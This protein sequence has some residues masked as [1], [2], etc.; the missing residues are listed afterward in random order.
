MEEKG[1]DLVFDRL[2][3]FNHFGNG[4]LFESR[5]FVKDIMNIVPARRKF[6]AHGKNRRMFPDLPDLLFTPVTEKMNAMRDFMIDGEDLYINTWVGR[7]SKYV[8]HRVGCVIDK[9][10]EMFNDILRAANL[11]ELSKSLL[12]YIPDPNFSYFNTKSINDF[13]VATQNKRKILMCNG[14]VGSLQA[15]NF[16]FTPMIEAVASNHKDDCFLLTT[17]TPL[18]LDNIWYT[19]DIIK[20]EDGFD[21]NEI[22]YLAKYVDII[23]G[24][25]SGPFVFAHPRDVWFD[26]TKKSLSF[27]YEAHSSHFVLQNDLPLRKLW[28]PSIEPEHVIQAMEVVIG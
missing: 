22:S 20:S 14:W 25:K 15:E 13:L 7:D 26:G 18:R 4:D 1:R 8:L 21:L 17:E 3:F 6:Y 10:Y 12:E 19:K 2:I 28:S 11:G 24:R 27:T 5:E 9:S 23:I 16:D